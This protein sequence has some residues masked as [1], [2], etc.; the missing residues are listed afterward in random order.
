MFPFQSILATPVAEVKQHRNN[1]ILA[2]SVE[3]YTKRMEIAVNKDDCHFV[4]RMGEVTVIL[5]VLS[6]ITRFCL[7]IMKDKR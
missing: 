7:I 1:L 2:G 4:H 3:S 5:I 6:Q